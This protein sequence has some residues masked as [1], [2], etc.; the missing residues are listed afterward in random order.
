MS[1]SEIKAPFFEQPPGSVSAY[2][3]EGDLSALTYTFVQL[4]TAR[5]RCV[6]AWASGISV[7]V[8]VNAPKEDA[9]STAFSTTALVQTSGKALVKAGTGDLAVGDLVKVDTGGVGVKA[10][11]VDNDIVVGQCEFAAVAGAIATV[12]LFQTYVCVA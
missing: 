8:L 4:D 9:S 2:D 1:S 11:P 6:K 10:T 3:V 5:A 12:R 7:G